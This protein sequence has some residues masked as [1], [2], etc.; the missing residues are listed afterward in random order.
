MGDHCPLVIQ[1][2]R[3]AAHMIAQ[4]IT[5]LSRRWCLA[6]CPPVQVSDVTTASVRNAD[7]ECFARGRV[8][9]DFQTR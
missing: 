4:G 5:P 3:A 9:P 1:L 2:Q 7:L 8:G 6:A